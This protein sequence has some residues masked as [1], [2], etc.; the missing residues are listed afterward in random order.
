MKSTNYYNAF[1]E[2]AEDCLADR[3]EIPQSRNDQKTVAQLQF[4]MIAHHPYAYT[5]DDVLFAVHATR[6]EISPAGIAEKEAFFAKPQACFRASPLGKRY[7]W[8]VH[9]NA[10]G[11]MALYAV[12][13]G[14]YE[15][16][17]NHPDLE[18]TRAMR[19]KR[20]K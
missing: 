9:Y 8:G 7:G 10:E 18:H 19:N 20:A 4:E 16:F 13:S 3:A 12:E 2:V 1:I 5:S 6:K 11:K 17:R 14:E 15:R